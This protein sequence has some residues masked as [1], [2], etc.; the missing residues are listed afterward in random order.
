MQ[1]QKFRVHAQV[2][3]VDDQELQEGYGATSKRKTNYVVPEPG[4]PESELNRLVAW[5]KRTKKYRTST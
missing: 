5:Q 2:T 1:M 3:E 4:G